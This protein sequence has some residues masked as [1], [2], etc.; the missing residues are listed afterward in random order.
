MKPV[1]STAAT[2]YFV[3]AVGASPAQS[4]DAAAER[5]LFE[6]DAGTFLMFCDLLS[7]RFRATFARADLA[8]RGWANV[9]LSELMH[10]YRSWLLVA[11]RRA[12]KHL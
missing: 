2:L 4:A 7:R 11:E 6:L 3:L 1:K 8:K 12:L 5:L 9:T 10:L